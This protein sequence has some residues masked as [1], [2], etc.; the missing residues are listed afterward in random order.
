MIRSNIEGEYMSLSPIEKVNKLANPQSLEPQF[1]NVVQSSH[2]GEISVSDTKALRAM[3]ALMDM[4]AVMGGAASHWGGPSAIAEIISSLFA[5]SFNEAKSKD[6]NWNELYHIIND[7]GHSE[8]IFYALK[9]NYK[10]AGLDIKDLKGFRSIESKLTGHGESHLFPEG[11]YLSNGPLGSSISQAQ[12]VCFADAISGHNNRVTISIISDGASMEGEAKEAFA[13]IPGLALKNKM[14]PFVMI[15]SDNNTK[16]SGRIDE[17]AYSMEMSFE[18][19]SALGWKVLELKNAHDL[20]ACLD[21]IEAAVIQAKENPQQPVA[22]HARTIK[23]YGIEATAKSAS[24]GHGFPLKKPQ[25]L[26]AFLSEIYKDSDVPEV[27][28]D[29]MNEQVQLENKKSSAAGSTNVD[30]E[31]PKEKI[32]LGI[33]KALIEGVKNSY[34]VFS[35]TSDLA[36]STGVAGFHKEFPNNFVD[37][38]VAESNMISM[39]AGLAKQGYIPIVDTFAQF[40]VTKGALPLTMAALSESPVIG[41]F[42]HIG[43]QDAADGASHQALAYYAMVSSI[44]HTEVYNLSCSEEAYQLLTQAIQRYKSMTEAGKTPPHQIFFLGR[45]NFSR[46]L[47]EKNYK[48]ELGKAQILFDSSQDF[49]NSFVIAACGAQ[50]TE[51]LSAANNLKAKGV[52]ATVVNLSCI[53]KVDKVALVAALERCKMNLLTVEEHQKVGGMAASIAISL[54]DVKLSRFI[55]LAVE[56]K[57]GQSAYKASDLY[58]KHGLD[59]AAIESA[60][61]KAFK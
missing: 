49:E 25:E 31:N 19:L 1:F 12:G 35:V 18:S 17:D 4:Q 32:Q 2:L 6:K 14:S 53:N 47:L 10:M 22:I 29:W 11:V 40:A 52:G 33:A 5:Y 51:A 20:Q 7:I 34:P 23:G 21:V 46:H 28:V 27:F 36:G 16:L 59:A 38:G 58:K 60:I 9:A 56:D 42:S 44:P 50:L 55:S 45:E 15:I 30:P 24:G 26:E 41:I 57:F 48:Y 37:V 43:F 3:V 39:A 54:Q 13:A 8:N 61:L